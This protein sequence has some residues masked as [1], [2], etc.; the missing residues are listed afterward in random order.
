VLNRLTKTNKSPAQRKLDGA[1]ESISFTS[2]L[3]VVVQAR[4]AEVPS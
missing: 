2:V 3:Q 1:F 4:L